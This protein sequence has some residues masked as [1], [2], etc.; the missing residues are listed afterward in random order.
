MKSTE[1]NRDL[2][3]KI[4]KSVFSVRVS[5]F[6]KVGLEFTQSCFTHK[7]DDAAD[8]LMENIQR[9]QVYNKLGEDQ[10]LGMFGAMQDAFCRRNEVID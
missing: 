5:Y 7:V 1:A 6:T 3:R 8:K 4:H 9:S 2:T 10:N